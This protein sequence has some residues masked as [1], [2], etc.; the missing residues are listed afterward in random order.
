MRTPIGLLFFFLIDKDGHVRLVIEKGSPDH[1]GCI[2]GTPK[3][4]PRKH[5]I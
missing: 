3:E 2:Q 1:T 4:R 5:G